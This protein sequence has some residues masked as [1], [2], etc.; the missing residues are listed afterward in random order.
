MTD[1]VDENT[2]LPQTEQSQSSQD[3]GL[4]TNLSEIIIRQQVDWREMSRGTEEPN[5]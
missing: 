5:Q 3:A 1:N 2:P 4:F